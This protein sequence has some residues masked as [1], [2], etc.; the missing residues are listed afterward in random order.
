MGSKIDSEPV[1]SDR[2]GKCTVELYILL[3]TPQKAQ[4]KLQI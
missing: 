2:D 3:L 1:I 4:Q